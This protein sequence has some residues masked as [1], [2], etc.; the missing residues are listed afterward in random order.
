VQS[1]FDSQHPLALADRGNHHVT[2]GSL[3]F[4]QR[5]DVLHQL[6]QFGACEI[7]ELRGKALN[8]AAQNA[9]TVGAHLSLAFLQILLSVLQTLQLVQLLCKLCLDLFLIGSELVQGFSVWPYIRDLLL[10]KWG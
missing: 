6:S 5:K 10:G 3:D 8:R 9:K 1:A 7:R 2:D 4:G